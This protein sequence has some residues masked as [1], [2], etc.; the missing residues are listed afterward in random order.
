MEKKIEEY[1]VFP[2]AQLGVPYLF[3]KNLAAAGIFDP[4]P[5]QMQ[6]IPPMLDGQD[7]LGIS[8]T[9]SGKT[10]AF[11]LPILAH[12]LAVGGKREPKTVRALILA[13][14]REL[15]VQIQE[16]V[17]LVA[18]NAH[19][20]ISLVLGGVSRFA[21]IKRMLAGVDILIATPGRLLD[22]V[23]EKN[24]NLSQTRFLI[25]DEADRMLDMGFVRDI[26]QITKLVSS[27]RQTALFSATMPKE[28][29]H[30]AKSLLSDPVVLETAPQ[31]MTV[32][33]ITQRV[34]NVPIRDKKRVLAG[35][36]G[37]PHFRSVIVFTRTKHGAD[38]VTRYLEKVG[39]PVGVIHGNKSQRAR[40][41]ALKDFRDGRIQV[42]IATDIA[43]R[44]IDVPGI[45]HVVNY[46]F[47]DE[48]ESYIHRIGR[49]GRNGA[50]GDATTL[51]DERVERARLHAVEKV[52]GRRLE[53]EALPALPP[54]TFFDKT[55]I[56]QDKLKLLKFSGKSATAHDA[57]RKEA[58]KKNVK[59]RS[60]RAHFA[61]VV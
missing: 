8:Q 48:A 46:E 16:S 18:K 49:T 11:I 59:K 5:V 2:F 42:L 36:L 47:P 24:I 38:S 53:S 39:F 21:Q 44:G 58:A 1:T 56:S 45:S 40:Q 34:Y 22:H 51:Y 20:S 15:A 60:A 37:C 3:V 19:F 9:G 12:I 23:R 27:N 10:L 14:T 41:C 25:L 6:A 43:A 4:K 28:I 7:L 52:I 26:R 50:L 29:V 30:L 55:S 35:L 31:G 33:E 57:V 13:P 54:V 32:A 61:K 17:H